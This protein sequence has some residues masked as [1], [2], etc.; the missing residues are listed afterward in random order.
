[1]N[2]RGA[3]LQGQYAEN[4]GTTANVAYRVVGLYDLVGQAVFCQVFRTL[5]NLKAALINTCEDELLLV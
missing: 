5:P 2:L 1:M 3:R 4:S